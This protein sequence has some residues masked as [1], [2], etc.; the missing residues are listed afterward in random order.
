MPQDEPTARPLWRWA[1]ARTWCVVALP[2]LALAIAL[3]L[4]GLAGKQD[5]ISGFAARDAAW[6]M[7]ACLAVFALTSAA[8]W[9]AHRLFLHAFA[10]DLSLAIQEARRLDVLRGP[11]YWPRTRIAELRALR[12]AVEQAAASLDAREALAREQHTVVAP[13]AHA[14]EPEPSPPPQIILKTDAIDVTATPITPS[15][16]MVA[17]PAAFIQAM[18]SVRRQLSEAKR[19]LD[20]LRAAQAHTALDRPADHVLAE[21]LLAALRNH[22]AEMRVADTLK[23]AL[24][25]TDARLYTAENE[26]TGLRAETAPETSQLLPADLARPGHP[27]LFLAIERAQALWID[28]AAHDPRCARV[29][30]ER[31]LPG[32]LSLVA[33]KLDG[34]ARVWVGVRP[35]GEHGWRAAEQVFGDAIARLHA[36]VPVPAQ[37]ATPPVEAPA[38]YAPESAHALWA[39][40]NLPPSP[41]APMYREIVDSA[42]AGLFTL[43]RAG[44]FSYANPVAARLFGADGAALLGQPLIARAAPGEDGA[45]QSALQRVL[46]G[47]ALEERDIHFAQGQGAQAL[48]RLFLSPLQ[49]EIGELTGIAGCV[50]DV[51]VLRSRELAL[52]R[53]EAVY[54]GI[55]EGAPQLLWS[56]DAIGCITFINNVSAQIYGF[57]PDEL[58]GRPITVLCDEAQA[59][60]DVE[61]LALLL[62]GK[63][64]TGYRTTH[65]HKDGTPVPLVVVAARQLDAAGRVT[66]AVGLAIAMGGEE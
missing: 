6:L 66:N 28:D 22:S 47:A 35:R 11:Y 42:A 41:D 51:T 7:K 16:A 29:F 45:V 2:W 8:L 58:I 55:V 10:Q 27:L 62:G 15:H 3:Y 34:G 1:F 43:N 46:E 18:D 56:V 63:P 39:Q 37:A 36:P 24:G 23:T 31:H 52:A 64:C 19:E 57:T 60:K 32:A 5:F 4:V 48:L 61:R 44:R 49:D 25:V 53:Q 50:L 26:F 17:P 9:L 40:P 12:V 14:M 54:R 13:A 30:A 59:R 33:L 38:P 21:R 20:D 65:R